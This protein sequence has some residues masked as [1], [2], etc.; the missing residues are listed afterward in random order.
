MCLKKTEIK[1]HANENGDKKKEVGNG[2]AA[3]Y[4]PLRTSIGHY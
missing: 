4:H 3:T 1:F 2:L